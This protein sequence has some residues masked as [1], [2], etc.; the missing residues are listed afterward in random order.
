MLNYYNHL[1]TFKYLTTQTIGIFLYANINVFS[2]SV[3]IS[4][5]NILSLFV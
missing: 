2:S 1:I 4:T 5:F 3:Q